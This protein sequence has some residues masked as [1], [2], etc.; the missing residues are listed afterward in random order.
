MKH[1]TKRLTVILPALV[2]TLALAV[3]AYAQTG[4]VSRDGKWYYY[5][6]N[7]IM[8]HNQWL[9]IKGNLYWISE[10][11]SMAQEMWKKSEKQ[12]FYLTSGGTAANGWEEI[13]GKWYYFDKDT[14][15]MATD[16]MV[17]RWYVGPDGAWDPS[18]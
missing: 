10:D 5:S 8:A 17:G 16:M 12:W 7:G 14:C 13:D 3:P 15:I 2:L 9:K 11:G 18:K 1:G 4:W 6:Q